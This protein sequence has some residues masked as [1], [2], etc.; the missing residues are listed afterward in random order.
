MKR[1]NLRKIR[2]VFLTVLLVGWGSE[3]AFAGNIQPNSL[4]YGEN[5]GWINFSPAQGPGVTVTDSAVTGDAWGENVGW[6]NLNPSTGGV[7][8]DG[9][10]HLSGYG[11]GENIGWINFAPTGG[12]VVIDK[13]TGKFSGYAWGENIGWINFAPTGSGV[14][15][16]WRP[17][18]TLSL[19]MAGTGLGTVSGAGTYTSGQTATVSATAN[20]GSTFSGWSGPNAA[21]CAGGSVLMNVN[22]SC[23]ATFNLNLPDLIMTN[24]TPNAATANQGGTLSVTDTAGNSG[25]A[26]TAFRIAYHLSGNTTYGDGDDVVISTIRVVTSLGAGASNTATTSLSIPSNAPGGTYHLCAMADSIAQV[27][28]SDETNNS[29]C[30]TGTVILP[31]ADLLMTAVSTSTTVIAPGKTL[32]LSNSVKNQG[33]FSAGSFTIGFYLSVNSNGSTQDV[34]IAATRTLGSL[35]TGATSTASTTLTIP[36]TTSLGTYYVC[37]DADSLN[38][39]AESDEGNNNLCMAGTIQVTLPDLTMTDVTPNALTANKGGTLSVTDTVSN[40]GASSGAFRIGYHLSPTASY[41]DPGAVVI[42]TTRTV[43]SLAA[44]ASSTGTTSLSVPRS[45]LSGTYYVCTLADSLNVVVETDEGNNTL[46]SGSQ[47]TV[48]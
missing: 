30:S 36:S 11:W 43:S 33:G 32:P 29:L 28:E 48:P 15:T 25:T 41:S 17:T 1:I 24:V 5:I 23:T 27:A 40:G 16:L 37:T 46:C 34:A 9:A 19:I 14:T 13:T 20:A 4:A 21:E 18:Y 45:T 42:T 8:N 31:S 38:Q 22:K 12:G 3:V 47:V 10:G 44:G 39:V 2:V 26:S 7:V 6:I 35:A